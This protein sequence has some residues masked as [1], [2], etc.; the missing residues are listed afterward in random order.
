MKTD[1]YAIK[2]EPATKALA[3]EVFQRHG[4]P[5]PA[6]AR[7]WKSNAPEPTRTRKAALPTS[8]AE[9]GA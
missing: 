6:S 1:H 9:S 5:R 8:E 3:E 7:T 4:S 2:R